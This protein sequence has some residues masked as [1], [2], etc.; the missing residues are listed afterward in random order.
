[1]KILELSYLINL[2]CGINQ[3]HVITRNVSIEVHRTQMPPL[4]H[5]YHKIWMDRQM[6]GQVK[7]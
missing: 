1:M 4:L 7:I 5:L 2:H 3:T 6:D